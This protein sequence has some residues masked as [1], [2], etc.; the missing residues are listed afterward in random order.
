VESFMD[1]LAA[2]AKQDP[3]AYR[4]ML[5][6]SDMRALNVLNLVAEKA[7]W[8]RPMGPESGRGVALAR[9]F[10][11][12]IAVVADVSIRASKV[13]IERL[14]FAVD[15][16]RLLDPGIATSNIEGG[17]IWGLSAMKTEVAFERGRVLQ[18][19]FDTFEPLHLWESPMIDVHFVAG[20]DQPGGTG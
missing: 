13:K 5:L 3:V 20:Q 10:G 14:T 18:S 17:A 9:A 19:N 12:H 8:G 4:R 11:G 15:C 1:E 16:G 7:N 2:A 6:T